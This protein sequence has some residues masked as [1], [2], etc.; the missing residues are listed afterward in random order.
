M[1]RAL[2]EAASGVVTRIQ[3]LLDFANDRGLKASLGYCG[4]DVTIRRP[5][6]IEVPERVFIEDKVSI[7][8]FLHIWGNAGVRIGSKTM[9]GS[10]VAITTAT[11]DPDASLMSETLIERP[12]VIEH[13]VWIGAHVVIMPG[14]TIGAQSVVAA[15]AV[16]L[17][18][19]PPGTIVAGVPAKVLR[20]KN[21]SD[22]T[23]RIDV[24]E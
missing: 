8:S 10:H 14:V 4:N 22:A 17:T 21:P 2:K 3:R 5:A 16:V 15:G 23:P 9:I 19:V 11:H 12:V 13:Q 24:A 7:A 18:D 20:V 1:R 6:V